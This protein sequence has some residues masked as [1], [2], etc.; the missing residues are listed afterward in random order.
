MKKKRKGQVALEF[1]MTY[2]WA[3]LIILVVIGAFIYFD[4]LNPQR[5]VPD[6]CTGPTGLSCT[7]AYAG[8]TTN[9]FTVTFANGIGKNIN[10][11]EDGVQDSSGTPTEVLFEFFLTDE[12]HEVSHDILDAADRSMRPNERKTIELSNFFDGA[13]MNNFGPGDKI[14]GEFVY[15]YTESGSTNPRTARTSFT[16]TVEE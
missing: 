10:I 3:F 7:N 16:M 4:V 1:L 13:P 14:T 5:L 15:R 8:Q 2:G 9:T 6:S 12:I 11:M